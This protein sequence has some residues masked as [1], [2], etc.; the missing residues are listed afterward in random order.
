VAV[1]AA[2]CI[3]S[4]AGVTDSVV[5]ADVIVGEGAEVTGSVLLD[6]ARVG[7]GARVVGSVI[8]GRVDDGASVER[9]VI[10]AEG[11][12]VADEVLVGV[13]RPDPSLA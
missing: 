5:A 13:K 9:S 12:V 2:A 6:G 11:V 10:G 4:D 8:M 7:A 3:A 1:A